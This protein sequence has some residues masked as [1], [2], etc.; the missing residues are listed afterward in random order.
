LEA[1]VN[2]DTN[3]VPPTAAFDP[4]DPNSFNSSTSITVF[5]SLGQE[6]LAAIFFRKT[7]ANAWDTHLV[8]D[9]D[10]A[11]TT[12]VV[13]LT[14]DSSGQLTSAQPV[15][16]GPFNPGS[17]ALPIDLNLNFTGTTQFGAA[18]GVNFLSQDGFTTGR[19]SG[20]DIDKEGVMLARFSNGQSQIQGQVALANFSNPQGLQPV[21]NTSWAETNSSGNPL[22]G[23]PASSSL[24]LIQSSALEESNVDI[25]EQLVNMIVAQRN[26]QANAQMIRTEDEATQTIIN[27]R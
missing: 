14:F 24:G 20:L 7:A 22:I 4:T 2:L 21:G 18:F 23:A 25:A 12:G 9:G 17:G 27:I 26:F 8:I 19:L 11:Q 13:G 10:T 16:Y 5:D 15:N 1:G 6:H 3:E